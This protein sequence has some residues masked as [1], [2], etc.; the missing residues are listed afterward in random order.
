MQQAREVDLG[1]RSADHASI[2][3][4][5]A[6]RAS[7]GGAYAATTKPPARERSGSVA[8]G[9]LSDRR[10]PSSKGVS[11]KRWSAPASRMSRR[12][13]RQTPITERG[14]RYR[15]TAA[16]STSRKATTT[17][18]ILVSVLGSGMR[19][20]KPPPPPVVEGPFGSLTGRALGL[21][22]TPVGPVPPEGSLQRLSRR[23]MFEPL[24]PLGIGS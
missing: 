13:R 6:V 18:T 8:S 5:R 22:T 1:L 10:R 20:P 12:V 16:N 24:T 17:P 9:K 7:S 14:R 19:I 11:P 4:A 23:Q 21:P 2:T 15:A 3:D